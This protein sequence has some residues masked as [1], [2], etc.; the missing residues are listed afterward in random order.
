MSIK[1]VDKDV[2]NNLAAYGISFRKK[3]DVMFKELLEIDFLSKIQRNIIS[4][5]ESVS[6]AD[7]KNYF[8]N[9]I[10]IDYKNSYLPDVAK[11]SSIIVDSMSKGEHIVLVTDY[12]S[13]GLNSAVVLVKTFKEHFN[14]NNITLLVNKRRHGN[15][16]NPTLVN[17]ILG[18]NGEKKIGLIITADHGSVNEEAYSLLKGKIKDLRIIVT[19]HHEVKEEIYPVSADAFV[20]HMRK[21]NEYPYS[22]SG[23]HVAF[24]TM[25]ETYKLLNNTNK[26]KPLYNLLPYVATSVI[27]DVMP[28]NVVINRLIVKLGLIEINKCYDKTWNVIRKINKIE[29]SVT[30]HDIAYI[31][32]AFINTANRTDSEDLGIAFLLGSDYDVLYKH[33]KSISKLNNMRKSVTKEVIKSKQQEVVDNKYS[34][35]MVLVIDTDIAISGI[36]ASRLGG[37]EQFPVICFVDSGEDVLTG[38]SRGIVDGINLMSAFKK[39][40]K[41]YPEVLLQYGGHKGAAGCKISK[42]GIE[43]FRAEFDKHVKEQ[44]SKIKISKH[45]EIDE[46]I[47]ADKISPQLHSAISIL[48]PYGNKWLEPVLATKMKI[49]YAKVYKTGFIRII[50][51]TPNGREVNGMMFINRNSSVNDKMLQ[52]VK[53][54]DKNVIVLYNLRIDALG[55]S[56]DITLNVIN[57]MEE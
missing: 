31:V 48:A 42:S 14:Y 7:S 11:A 1:F 23:C 55:G 57:I 10:S 28:L 20:N 33:G 53:M 37:D 13:D 25:V 22:V 56:K 32:G 17:R 39:I 45:I 50:F 21:D 18:V 5:R 46:Y 35:S 38:S 41:D 43:I 44:F 16:I 30:A 27:T 29:N 8:Y 47:T 52:D 49:G 12:D 19:D 36:V 2:V 9:G 6:L 3:D 15:G 34:N 51:K 24:I 40:H 54:Y 4:R 26:L